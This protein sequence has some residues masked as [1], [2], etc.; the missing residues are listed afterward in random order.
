MTRASTPHFEPPPEGP[1]TQILFVENQKRKL[2][3]PQHKQ[4]ALPKHAT[5]DMRRI[6]MVWGITW[7]EANKLTRH[8][9]TL[10]ESLLDVWITSICHPRHWAW[11]ACW[12]RL[13]YDAFGYRNH[14]TIEV[15]RWHSDNCAQIIWTRTWARV[16]T[17]ARAHAFTHVP[18]CTLKALKISSSICVCRAGHWICFV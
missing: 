6:Q 1:R 12:S 15:H 13:D 2:G 10:T 11:N 3:V 8:L 5:H 9:A 14:F 4:G 18:T 16:Q 17:H 7:C